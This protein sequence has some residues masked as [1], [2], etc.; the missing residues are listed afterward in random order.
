MIQQLLADAGLALSQCDALAF[1][2]GPGSFTG[3]RTACGVV[4]GRRWR[5]RPSGSSGGDAGSG[6]PGL[7]R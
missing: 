2:V 5:L 3:V 1:G 7:P 6:S 4:Q